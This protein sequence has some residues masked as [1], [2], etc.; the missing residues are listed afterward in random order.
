[1]HLHKI[2]LRQY[3]IPES[4]KNTVA[5]DQKILPMRIKNVVLKKWPLCFFLPTTPPTEMLG[6][7][8][9]RLSDNNFFLSFVPLLFTVPT[10]ISCCKEF[11]R[12]CYLLFPLLLP[13]SLPPSSQLR[14]TYFLRI[15]SIF[16]YITLQKWNRSASFPIP[17]FMY[18]WAIYCIITSISLPAWLQQNRQAIFANI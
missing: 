2:K 8:F 1:M 6:G 16:L 15:Y 17:T 13:H 7:T 5:L 14:D 12:I 3:T 18:M 10:A 11:L 4:E 9:K